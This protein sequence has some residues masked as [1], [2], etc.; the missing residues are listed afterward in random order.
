MERKSYNSIRFYHIGQRTT[1]S[2]QPGFLLFGRNEYI[3]Q[4]QVGI[5]KLWKV[6]N[7]PG[8]EGLELI[9][10]IDRLLP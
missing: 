2:Q 9:N 8:K 5:K 1:Q 10:V 4:T 7:K 3:K 6:F